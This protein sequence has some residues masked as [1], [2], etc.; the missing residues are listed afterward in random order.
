MFFAEKNG[1][2]LRN[3][4]HLTNW[5]ISGYNFRIK[6]PKLNHRFFRHF[7]FCAAPHPPRHRGDFYGVFLFVP[8]G[9]CLP[10]PRPLRVHPFAS[11]GEFRPQQGYAIKSP[12]GQKGCRAYARRGSRFLKL[13]TTLRTLKTT[14]LRGTP[15]QEENL[16][17]DEDTEHST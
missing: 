12:Y 4:Y 9:T 6:V 13:C 17:S 3:K 8:A 14:P 10:L 2:F 7:F 11:E 1:G 5:R 15:P 16:V